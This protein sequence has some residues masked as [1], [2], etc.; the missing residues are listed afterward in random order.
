MDAQ[1]WTSSFFGILSYLSV[2]LPTSTFLW[3][4]LAPGPRYP[5]VLFFSS[6]ITFVRPQIAFRTTS[7]SRYLL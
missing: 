6:L 7:T 2:Y 4:P 5:S 3:V 1:N